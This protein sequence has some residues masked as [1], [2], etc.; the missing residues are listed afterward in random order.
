MFADLNPVICILVQIFEKSLLVIYGLIL[1][2]YYKLSNVNR[3]TQ[4]FLKKYQL[5]VHR[6]HTNLTSRLRDVHIK[7]SESITF[8]NQN[9]NTLILKWQYLSVIN[10]EISLYFLWIFLPF[11]LL[12]LYVCCAK[13]PVMVWHASFSPH[14]NVSSKESLGLLANPW[15]FC[16]I[17]NLYGM[18]YR[19]CLSWCHATSGVN[20]TIGIPL[21][22]NCFFRVFFLSVMG[23]ALNSHAK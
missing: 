21:F 16:N 19:Q 12:I 9:N 22:T 7:I 20:P 4:F 3:N 1:E 18:F 5:F 6:C 17:M 23:L 8:L 10:Y 13:S 15:L 11:S 2:M 14:A